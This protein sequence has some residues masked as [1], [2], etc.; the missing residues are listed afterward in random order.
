MISYHIDFIWL[1]EKMVGFRLEQ[2][3]LKAWLLTKKRIVSVE[4]VW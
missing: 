2:I 1:M 3:V 4:N